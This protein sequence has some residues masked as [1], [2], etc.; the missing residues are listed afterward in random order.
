[1][2]PL[3]AQMRRKTPT[4]CLSQQQS[5]E[6]YDTALLEAIWEEQNAGEQ[7]LLTDLF[8][9]DPKVA[10]LN[11]TGQP[12]PIGAGGDGGK[13]HLAGSLDRACNCRLTNL[14]VHSH[15]MHTVETVKGQY[16][17]ISGVP[18]E[19]GMLEEPCVS[20]RQGFWA[21]KVSVIDKGFISKDGHGRG[22]GGYHHN[23]EREAIPP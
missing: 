4:W 12:S 19:G 20:L 7:L 23:S 2:V 3:T 15:L 22:V 8:L 11:N 9:H 6:A 16:C 10:Q 14:L 13:L 18:H 17:T 5:T 21:D 1:M